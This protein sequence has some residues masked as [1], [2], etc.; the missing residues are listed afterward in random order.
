MSIFRLCGFGIVVFVTSILIAGCSSNDTTSSNGSTEQATLETKGVA[1]QANQVPTSQTGDAVASNSGSAVSGIGTESASNSA[2][3]GTVPAK[4]PPADTGLIKSEMQAAGLQ[5]AW[6]T[7]DESGNIRAIAISDTPLTESALKFLGKSTT[8]Y[9]IQIA[10]SDVTDD[11][12]KHFASLKSLKTL[13]I[14]QS[15]VTG[16]G[17]QHLSGTENLESLSFI[18]T[19]LTDQGL[20]HL[21]VLPALK[22]LSFLG[23][24]NLS[25]SG[26]KHLETFSQLTTLNL[27]GTG[28]SD[29]GLARI[30]KALPSCMVTA[31][32]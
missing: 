7:F 29:E 12:L 6:P 2:I 32:K 27:T 1:G 24:K 25:D 4:T 28:V 20:A 30:Q 11:G 18:E 8:L 22:H 15:K 16:L 13:E 31:L 21:P 10:Y 14:D 17:L 23:C 19:P 3:S 9:K 26:L 5:G